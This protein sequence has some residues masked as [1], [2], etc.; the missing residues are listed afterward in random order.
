MESE[1]N[2]FGIVDA[3]G[4]C[5]GDGIDSDGDGFC[6]AIDP[7]LGDYDECGICNGEG[8]ILLS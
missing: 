7:C 2:Y 5:G 4:V 6:D 1:D 3:C 8:R